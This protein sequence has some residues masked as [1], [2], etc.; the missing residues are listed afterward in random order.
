MALKGSAK[1]F[2]KAMTP[3]V[4]MPAARQNDSYDDW[5]DVYDVDQGDAQRE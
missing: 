5:A 3:N 4:S 1:R 2:L